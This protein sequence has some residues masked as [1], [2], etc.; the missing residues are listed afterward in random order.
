MSRLGSLV[1]A[2]FLVALVPVLVPTGGASAA[3]PVHHVS[4]SGT[5]VSGTYPSYSRSVTRYGVRTASDRDGTV[6]VSATTSEP[7]GKVYVDGVPVTGPTQVHGLSDGDEVS[8]SITD[9]SGTT[10]QSFVYLPAGFPAATSTSSG[11]GPAPGDV[12]LTLTSPATTTKFE[13]VVDAHGVPVYVRQTLNPEDLKRQPDGSYSV[14]RGRTS[15]LSSTFDIV[16]LDPTFHQVASYTTKD[17]TDTEFHDSI[18]EP[19]GGRILMAYEP[20]ADTGKTDS[21]VQEVGSD[22]T[23]KLLWNS[24]DH[25]DP[26]TDGL[27]NLAD[28]AHLNSIDVMHDGDLLLSF[29]HLSQVMKIDR[30]TGAVLWRL[31]GKRSDFSFP[32]DPYG[33]PC[34]QHT[35]RELAN[36]DIMVWDN[37]SKVTSTTLQPMCPDPANPTGARVERPFSRVV[38]YHLD[39]TTHKATVVWQHQTGEFTEF[40]GSAQRLGGRTASDHTLLGTAAGKDTTSGD[41]APDAIELDS[42]DNTVWT[43]SYPDYFSY[44]AL[45]YAAPDRISPEVTLTGL[46]DGATYHE[47]DRLRADFSCTDRGGSSLQQCQ[48]TSPSGARPSSSPGAH[49]FVVRATDGAGNTTTRTAHYTVLAATQPDAMIRR[50]GGA[51]VGNDVYRQLPA[52]TLRFVHR[53]AGAQRAVVRFTDDGF[54]PDTVVVNGTPGTARFPVHYTLA[55]TDVTARV[56]GGRLSRRLEPGAGFSLVMTMDRVGRFHRGSTRTFLLRALSQTSG[57]TD[58]VAAVRG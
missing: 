42:A 40:A 22:G 20:N 52:Q 33:G 23:V 28:Y 3:A 45:K 51:F 58:R 46:S 14:A 11:A 21:I 16:Q 54:Q 34:A 7:T 41:E 38:E 53:A 37:G 55:G 5:G 48:G 24:K 2:S 27:T 26:A 17:L 9:S 18:L 4:V 8:V 30:T 1:A 32:D 50:P 36:G 6:T 29:R 15:A 31:G 39:E 25:V 57:R 49:T 47:G 56:V 13:A 10:N 44:R 35:A 43:L 12:F 19:D